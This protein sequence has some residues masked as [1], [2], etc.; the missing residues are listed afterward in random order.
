MNGKNLLFSAG[1]F[2]GVVIP[3]S[4][5]DE[6]L[7]DLPYIELFYQYFSGSGYNISKQREFNP[8]K[9]DYSQEPWQELTL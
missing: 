1:F 3:E 2:R 9:Y 4:Q 5:L 7:D 6:E 8:T